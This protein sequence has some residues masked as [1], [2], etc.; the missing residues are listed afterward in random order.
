MNS[1]TVIS[2]GTIIDGSGAE[3]FTGDVLVRD[4]RI[5]EVGKVEVPEGAVV[6]DASGLNVT[7]GF[8]DIHSHSDY[9]LYADP[10]AVSAITQGVTLEV[11]GNCGHG[12]APF[13]NTEAGR[14]N[15]YGYIPGHQIPWRSVG[16][17]IEALE[18]RRPAVN[19]VV[20]IP[21]GCLRLSAV[22]SFD[23]PSTKD[24]IIQMKRL[25]RSGIEEGAFGYS[26]GLEYALEIECTETEIIELCKEVAG[27]GGFYATH[28]RNRLGE[29][30]E[31][32]AEAIRA[33]EN[34]NAA[35]QISHI[36]CV[37]RLDKSGRRALEKAIDQVDHARNQGLDV[38][39]DMHTRM[40]GMTSLSMALPPWS[41]EGSTSV[42]MRR[43]A[44]MD[45]RSKMRSYHSIVTSLANGDW[46]RMAVYNCP[47]QPEVLGRS[48][49]DLAEERGCEPFDV[50][51]DI[52][53]NEGDNFLDVLILAFVYREEDVHLAYEHPMCMVGS[54]AT[55]LSPEHSPN[56]CMLHGA[57]TW[58]AWFWRHFVRD[59]GKLTPQES[60][61]RLTSLP[62]GRLGLTDRG[63]LKPG[64]WA[65][66]SVFE[67]Q[68]F[69]EC[70]N[71]AQPA[72]TAVG[73][74]YVLVNGNIAVSDGKLTGSQ[75]GQVLRH[76]PV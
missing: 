52:L 48:V 38:S 43:L 17:Y 34:S 73:M 50:I 39:F 66:I 12:C 9:T 10:R 18:S 11:V 46:S 37:A 63:I 40:F 58:A 65:D 47:R 70:G 44:D 62:A 54:D 55:T 28:T 1:T 32:I 33:C 6:I 23:R 53:Q 57:F 61:R 36:G 30:Q 7:P 19:V 74:K 21:N 14:A 49:A 56:S 4:G 31:T 64:A 51:C 16:E 72:L 68:Q 59:T 71:F 3:P 22:G 42:V 75:N 60:V 45:A 35:L 27:L 29:A 24:E 69:A 41:L 26:T 5:V 8:I 20:L 67:P 76:Q 2:G 25:L 13:I 15:I